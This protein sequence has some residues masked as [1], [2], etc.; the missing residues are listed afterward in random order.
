MCL[1]IFCCR[2]QKKLA[3][4]QEGSK[5]FVNLFK[6]QEEKIQPEN[7]NKN[8]GAIEDNYTDANNYTNANNY[9]S[10]DK[11]KPS[12]SINVDRRDD[13]SKHDTGN[14]NIYSMVDTILFQETLKSG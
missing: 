8:P 6:E 2:T 14:G 11:K 4:E 9:I 10:V 1:C 13:F 5:A 7:N 3:R 12:P